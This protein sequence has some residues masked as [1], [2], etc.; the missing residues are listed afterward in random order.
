VFYMRRIEL[1]NFKVLVKCDIFQL[2]ASS[3][4]CSPDPDEYTTVDLNAAFVKPVP[5]LIHKFDNL[6][7]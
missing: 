1:P 7:S 4:E 2:N 5:S 3:V 6:H